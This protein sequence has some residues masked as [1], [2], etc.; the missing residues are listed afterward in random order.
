MNGYRGDMNYGQYG[1]VPMSKYMRRE[2]RKLIEDLDDVYMIELVKVSP[3]K[4]QVVF[5][6]TDADS[7][8]VEDDNLFLSYANFDLKLLTEQTPIYRYNALRGVYLE[9]VSI[10]EFETCRELFTVTREDGTEVTQHELSA[11]YNVQAKWKE[12]RRYE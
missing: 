8:N 4:W 9:W 6:S 7:Y 10:R 5:I 12:V 1:T 2:Y 3:R 11:I